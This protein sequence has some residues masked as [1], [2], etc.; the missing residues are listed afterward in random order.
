MISAGPAGVTS[1]RLRG[2]KRRR[3]PA[4]EDGV[5]AKA[6]PEC[7]AI[8]SAFE[9]YFAGDACALDGLSVDLSAVQSEFQRVV[10]LTLRKL[11]P[12]G[13]TMSYGELA[14]AAGR[15]GAARAVGAIMA[16]N[17]VPLILP[18]HRVLA[19]DG[20]LHGYGGGLQMKRSLLAMEGAQL[21]AK[22]Q[23]R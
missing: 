23:R 5:R 13:M 22:A 19:S 21:S 1:V 18:C 9:R 7:R 11:V 2:S 17:P 10:L 15:P 20:T 14:A 6:P 4:S 12:A 3:R 8:A 16:N